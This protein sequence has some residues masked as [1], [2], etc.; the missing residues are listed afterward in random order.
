MSKTKIN[1]NLVHH[2]FNKIINIEE[3][4]HP[5]E[6]WTCILPD[7]I[8]VRNPELY[9]ETVPGAKGSHELVPD[10][11]ERIVQRCI[12]AVAVRIQFKCR[13]KFGELCFPDYNVPELTASV[14]VF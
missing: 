9:Y 3:Y 1:L 11:M 14:N 5:T 6:K 10:I 2:L 8:D 4:Y 12:D 13:D 7:G